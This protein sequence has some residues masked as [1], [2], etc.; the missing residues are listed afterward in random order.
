MNPAEQTAATVTAAYPGLRRTSPLRPGA[1]LT[2]VELDHRLT[3]RYSWHGYEVDV[4]VGPPE[5]L[6]RE[7]VEDTSLQRQVR[8]VATLVVLDVQGA[9]APGHVEWD[10]ANTRPELVFPAASSAAAADTGDPRFASAVLA[11][12]ARALEHARI[13]TA[14]ATRRAATAAEEAQWER[15]RPDGVSRLKWL[16]LKRE[17]RDQNAAATETAVPA[18]ETSTPTG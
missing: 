2:E 14:E 9:T 17:E 6:N 1:P 8:A 3:T 11:T 10:L 16:R 7:D 18:G 13:A 4:H 12:V 15:E 5:H